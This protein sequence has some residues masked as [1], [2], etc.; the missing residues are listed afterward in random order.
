MKVYHP[1]VNDIVDFGEEAYLR[2][3]TQFCAVPSDYRVYL[4]DIGIDSDELS[5][6][7]LFTFICNF[8]EPEESKILFGDL[9]FTRF[10]L[11]FNPE[12]GEQI[13]KDK[14]SDVVIDEATYLQMV[15]FVRSINRI[16]RPSQ[17]AGNEATKMFLIEDA[18]LAAQILAQNPKPF[19]SIYAPLISSMANTPGFKYNY[20]EIFSLPIYT[21]NDAVM[22]T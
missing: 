5:D 18:R 14:I 13:L 4:Y 2:F 6:F 17:I 19:E 20:S 15:K 22:R 12:N 11:D 8:M 1:T 10:T 16:E 9:D 7:S 3:V 21:F